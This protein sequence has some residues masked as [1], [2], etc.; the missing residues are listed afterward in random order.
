MFLNQE[1]IVLANG[2]SRCLFFVAVLRGKAQSLRKINL[3]RLFNQHRIDESGEMVNIATQR[4][5]EVEN[6]ELNAS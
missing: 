5:E 1:K 6:H 3:R 2:H 4:F